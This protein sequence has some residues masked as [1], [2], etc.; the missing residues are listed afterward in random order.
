MSMNTP[1]TDALIASLVDDLRPV[2]PLRSRRA[3]VM[4]GAA[5]VFTVLAVVWLEG[6]RADLL[7]VRFDPLFLIASGLY[8]LL[9]MA[10]SV[11]VIMMGMPRVGNDT[12]GWKWAAAMAG[13]LPAVGTV[14]LFDGSHHGVLSTVYMGVP[15]TLAGMLSSSLTALLLVMWLRRGAPTSPELAGLLTGVGAGSLGI[16][17]F[18]FHCPLVDIVHIGLWHS[19]AVALSAGLG[20]V[21]VP[22]LV[23]W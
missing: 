11:A 5:L 10:A 18:S 2:Q 13:L 8:L 6:L 23:R 20:R 12:G 1:T 7:N 19:L 22:P 4:L 21:I 14:M 3:F 15:C 17:A 16:F 9:G